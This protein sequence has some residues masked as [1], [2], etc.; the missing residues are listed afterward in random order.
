MNSP[1][2]KFCWQWK[3][4]LQ[5]TGTKVKIPYK[6][7]KQ[8]DIFLNHITTKAIYAMYAC[9]LSKYTYQ[10]NIERR[11]LYQNKMLAKQSGT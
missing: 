7:C 9:T 5:E 6:I 8:F 11:H 10:L 1:T 4:I 2:S 3:N